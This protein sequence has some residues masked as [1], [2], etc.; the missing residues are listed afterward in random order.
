L[1]IG[2]GEAGSG[3]HGGPMARRHKAGLPPFAHRFGAYGGEFGR[4]FDAAKPI[5]DDFD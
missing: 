5:E 2:N 3:D 1:Q 4:G